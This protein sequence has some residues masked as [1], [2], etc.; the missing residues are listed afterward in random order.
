MPTITVDK[1]A[2]FEALG[3][4][5]SKEEFEDLCFEFGVEMDEDT[6][7]DERPAGVPPELKIGAHLSS[8]SHHTV[9]L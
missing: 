6:E 9:S 7:E 2:L 1:Y 8:E 4:K 3:Q 5:Y